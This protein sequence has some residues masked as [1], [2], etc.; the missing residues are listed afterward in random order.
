MGR[1]KSNPAHPA[2][3]PVNGLPWIRLYTTLPDDGR[4]LLLGAL[5]GNPDAYLHMVARR[6][7]HSRSAPDGV[8]R[9]EYAAQLVETAA[10]WR[11][12]P[13][14]FLEA[15][16]KAGFI[17]SVVEYDE[18]APDRVV[19]YADVSWPA[20][21]AAHVAKKARDDERN[22]R[23]A[24][25]ERLRRE[26]EAN[27]DLAPST[28][29]VKDVDA[30]HHA[31]STSRKRYLDASSARA[32]AM[33]SGRDAR[34]AVV[35]DSV[36]R[37]ERRVESREKASPASQEGPG[38]GPPPGDAGVDAELEAYVEQG[39]REQVATQPA[40]VDVPPS[41]PRAARQ[42]SGRQPPT[43][44]TT[45]EER[46]ARKLVE[47]VHERVFGKPYR[48][49]GED[50]NA[51]RTCLGPSCAASDLGALESLW[52]PGACACGP[53]P[54]SGR[55][56]RTISAR[57]RRRARTTGGSSS[58]RVGTSPASPRWRS[59]TRGRASPWPPAR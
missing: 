17:T 53:W 28:P 22:R 38:S 19:G 3:G 29:H 54:A 9:G 1:G 32:E 10:A 59:R 18:V 46:E 37:R 49:D 2:G 16:I 41:P 34:A 56:S 25:D 42:P 4:S 51:L 6:P 47:E 7:S 5:L 58:R 33:K 27:G 48:W 40:L 20:E 36:E 8:V 43:P 24:E 57:R 55:S 26:A 11:G 50:W 23:R 52:G 21:Q 13:G 14:Q 31:T 45:E 15:A 44:K 39:I 12:A 30:S 35:D